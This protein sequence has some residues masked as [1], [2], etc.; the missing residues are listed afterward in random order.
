ML[1]PFGNRHYD[2]PRPP[3]Q[4]ATFHVFL[5]FTD[6]IDTAEKQEVV[7]I[8]TSLMARG[9]E[10]GIE[11]GIE[12]GRREGELRLLLRFAT[13][14][15]GQ[16]PAVIRLKI[17][18]LTTT[19]IEQV[20]DRIPTFKTVNELVN[21]LNALET[22]EGFG[23]EKLKIL[24]RLRDQVGVIAPEQKQQ[25]LSLSTGQWQTLSTT[26]FDN[27]SALA[28]WLAEENS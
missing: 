9:I 26:T 16:L 3:V 23:G 5:E 2:Q 27:I 14:L 18:G 13:G 17:E 20:S 4:R 1:N 22:V 7:E 21:A 19:Q 6:Q 15:F 8:V 28:H 25:L 24:D 10:Q 12:R 11:Q